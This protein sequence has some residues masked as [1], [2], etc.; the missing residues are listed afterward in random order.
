MKFISS[1]VRAYGS[2]NA[3]VLNVGGG[4]RAAQATEDVEGNCGREPKKR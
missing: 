4:V 1:L 2:R 3:A